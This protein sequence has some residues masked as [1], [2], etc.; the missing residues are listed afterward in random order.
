MDKPDHS[1]ALTFL[2]DNFEIVTGLFNELSHE[3]R[4]Q[5]ADMFLSY[6]KAAAG[7]DFP[8][9]ISQFVTLH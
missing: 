9:L 4:L 3:H 1:M 8:K 7:D 2:A 6:A 5:I